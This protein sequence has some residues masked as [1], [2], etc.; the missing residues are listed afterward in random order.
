MTGIVGQ[1]DASARSGQV[2]GVARWNG[3]YPMHLHPGWDG[4]MGIGSMSRV[5]LDASV[6]DVPVRRLPNAGDAV[7][8]IVTGPVGR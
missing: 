1:A 5:Q 4:S 3:S 8:T 7:A 6:T 2:R